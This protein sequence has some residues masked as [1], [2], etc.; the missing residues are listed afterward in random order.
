MDFENFN[1][2]LGTYYAFFPSLLTISLYVGIFGGLEKQKQ[3][4]K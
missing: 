1:D 3:P 4:K 2:L